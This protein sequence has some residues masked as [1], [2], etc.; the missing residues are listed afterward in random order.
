MGFVVRSVSLLALFVI[1]LL[2][3]QLWACTCTAE[4][5]RDAKKNADIVFAGQVE[6]ITPVD[7]QFDWEPRLIVRFNVSRVWKG[8]VVQSFTMHS[9]YESS[10]CQG[11][12]RQA[13]EVGRTLLVYA[14]SKPAA[15]WKGTGAGGVSN[16]GGSTVRTEGSAP[17]RPE[18][19]NAIPDKQTLFTTNIC[20]RTMPVELA[21]EDFDQL[22]KAE[23]LSMLRATPDPARV[24][25]MR[26]S[27]NG[28]PGKCSDLGDAKRWRKLPRAPANHAQL[29]SLME[30]MFY[31]DVPNPR[32]TS[33]R[34]YW[35]IGASGKYG[36]CR[37]A[38]KPD[39]VCGE[40]EVEFT[41]DSRSSGQW[42]LGGRVS[43]FC[44]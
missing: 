27:S 13:L 9:N 17:T 21:V 38:I 20:S 14:Y 12:T 37:T 16:G 34:D 25:E 28:L 10:S 33:Y 6:E 2:P 22:G 36:L 29:T 39:V 4:G 11:F 5:V 15:D 26:L 32:P 8:S 23:E 18:L 43:T 31:T 44:D 41:Q 24:A 40:A 19:I 7:P 42:K 1:T 30:S 35:V 3:R